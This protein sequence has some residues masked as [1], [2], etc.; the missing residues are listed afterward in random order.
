MSLSLASCE[1]SFMTDACHGMTGRQY[2][3]RQHLCSL[4]QLPVEC[5][6]RQLGDPYL[7]P[8]GFLLHSPHAFLC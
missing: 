8:A 7:Q 4:L 6:F 1:K 2:C 3:L 5:C